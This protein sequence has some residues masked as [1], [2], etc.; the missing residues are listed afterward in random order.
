MRREPASLLSVKLGA[1]HLVA[2]F[3]SRPLSLFLFARPK[4]QKLERE[5]S[6]IEL[7]IS[8]LS[9]TPNFCKSVP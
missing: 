5:V 2:L 1:L 6:I 9:P 7:F 3:D 8:Y 4:Q